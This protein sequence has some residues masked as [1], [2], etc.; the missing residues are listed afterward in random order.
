MTLA[1]LP[2]PD[3]RFHSGPGK[4]IVVGG[5]LSETL[6]GGLDADLLAG[7]GGNDVLDGGAGVDTAVF[8]GR[9]SDYHVNLPR[10]WLHRDH[11][12]APRV[13]GRY[14][15]VHPGR[16]IHLL[17]RQLRRRAAPRRLHHCRHQRRGLHQR[18][19]QRP[20][21]PLP[22]DLGD[23]IFG[24][25]GADTIYG[26]GGNDL[27]NGGAGSDQI[28]GGPGNDVLLGGPGDD[29][30]YGGPGNDRLDGGTGRNL[31]AGGG[32]ADHFVF[33]TLNGN[34]HI[35]GFTHGVDKIVVAAA[36]FTSLAHV[37]YDAANG[38]LLFD[39]DGSG[40]HAAVQFGELASHLTVTG[41]DFLF[42]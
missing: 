19:P 20:G 39:P 27:I 14:R 12:P 40:G 6:Y 32:G 7:R 30:L 31:L 26:L 15:P 1:P 10:Q 23:R 35:V 41:S 11:G 9:R 2:R 25:G 37:H 18:P 24:R 8:S 29:Q 13:A 38:A 16:A 34:S 28:F 3:R 17:R 36:V 22:T 21:K 5:A 42:V 33:R 4:D